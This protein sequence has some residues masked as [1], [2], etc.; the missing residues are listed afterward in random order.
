MSVP[1][2]DPINEGVEVAPLLKNWIE[3]CELFLDSL[4]EKAIK[5]IDERTEYGLKKYGQP[6]MS[7]D[8]RNSIEDARQELGDL[9]QYVFKAILNH[10]D[11]NEIY[12][13]LM[14]LNLLLLGRSS[15]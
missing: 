11:V 4:K 1:E 15:T 2:P 6:L 3:S 8:G 7:K 10:E 5:L 14:I 13:I 9:I 12:E